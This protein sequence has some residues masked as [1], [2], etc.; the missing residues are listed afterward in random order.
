MVTQLVK[1]W[2]SPEFN[3]S[4]LFTLPC[5]LQVHAMGGILCGTTNIAEYC[6]EWMKGFTTSISRMLKLE[7]F[8]ATGQKQGLSA[9]FPSRPRLFLPGSL[10]FLPFS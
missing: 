1:S 2:R 9:H 8:L 3:P 7:S 6:G 10:S 4:T 5:H